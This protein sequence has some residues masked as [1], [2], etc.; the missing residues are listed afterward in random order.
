VLHISAAQ[1]PSF[2]DLIVDT[3]RG[4][5]T[6]SV[7][8]RGEA[9]RLKGEAGE[10]GRLRVDSAKARA[11]ASRESCRP[12]EALPTGLSSNAWLAFRPLQRSPSWTGHSLSSRSACWTGQPLYAN[13]CGTRRTN[14]C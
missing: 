8:L 5:R 4:K 9:G 13:S 14:H 12:S 10:A 3:G 7:D 2:D 11:E 6:A 1:L